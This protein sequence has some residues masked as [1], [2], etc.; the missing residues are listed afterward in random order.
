MSTI[1]ATIEKVQ[2]VPPAGTVKA[3][4]HDPECGA[5]CHWVKQPTNAV[6]GSN[7]NNCNGELT[8]NHRTRLATYQGADWC[9]CNGCTMG[10][11]KTNYK[12]YVRGNRK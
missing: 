4:C 10:D 8:F 11:L 9:I 7:C 1:V 3:M 12:D 6:S 2:F 5:W